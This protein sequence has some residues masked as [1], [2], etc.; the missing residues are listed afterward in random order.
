MAV[1]FITNNPRITNIVD[2]LTNQM[3]SELNERLEIVE[4]GVQWLLENRVGQGWGYTGISI[5]RTEQEEVSYLHMWFRRQMR[6]RLY[7]KY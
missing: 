2:P 1:D 6:L 3:L 5:W 7:H 4:K